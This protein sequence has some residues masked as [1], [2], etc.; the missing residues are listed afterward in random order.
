[1]NAAPSIVPETGTME[2]GG[3]FGAPKLEGAEKSR[4]P[5]K[6]GWLAGKKRGAGGYW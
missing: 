1:M 5:L 2:P 6:Q 4:P 3:W